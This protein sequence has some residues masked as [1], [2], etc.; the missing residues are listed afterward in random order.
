MNN[1]RK[2]KLF[3]VRIIFWCKRREERFVAKEV[4]RQEFTS[5]QSIESV[6]E[7]IPNNV[8]TKLISVIKNIGTL[9][10][11]SILVLVDFSDLYLHYTLVPLD[12]LFPY[13]YEP[14]PGSETYIHTDFYKSLYLSDTY[15]DLDSCTAR[16][17]FQNYLSIT[18]IL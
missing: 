1:N 9:Y 4:I 8:T 18:Y 12:N 6:L 11:P 13:T 7:L 15:D 3:G 10:A 5:P 14:T 16:T 17:V 2:N